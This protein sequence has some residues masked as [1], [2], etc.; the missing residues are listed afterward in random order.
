M[1]SLVGREWVEDKRLIVF[2]S[3]IIISTFTH[4]HNL[5]PM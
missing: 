4:V 2:R 5:N 3:K 1:F